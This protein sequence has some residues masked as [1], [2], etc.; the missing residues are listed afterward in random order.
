LQFHNI[1]DDL[2]NSTARLVVNFFDHAHVARTPPVNF[3]SAHQNGTAKT[4]KKEGLIL[5]HNSNRVLVDFLD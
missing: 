5:A 3:S 2:K 4:E 1:I